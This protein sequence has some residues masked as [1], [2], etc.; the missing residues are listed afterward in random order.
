[1]AGG[2]NWRGNKSC[3]D[4]E[5]RGTCCHAKNH[6]SH[7]KMPQDSPTVK[8]ALRKSRDTARFQ[9]FFVYLDPG[10]VVFLTETVPGGLDSV[11]RRSSDCRPEEE[12][13]E[14]EHGTPRRRIRIS[15]R[16]NELKYTVSF[17]FPLISW[18]F[19]SFRWFL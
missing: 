9:P 8:R 14:G 17:K 6:A 1:M 19:T 16:T 10:E 5:G 13:I 18:K 4:G 11:L 15:K 12:R 2:L 3:Q 7:L